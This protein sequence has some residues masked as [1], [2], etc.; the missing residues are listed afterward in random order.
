MADYSVTLD[1]SNETLGMA[2]I[3][4]MLAARIHGAIGVAAQNVYALW[5]DRVMKAPGIWH[6]ERVAYVQ[7]LK[8]NYTGD[9]SA[10]V[11]TDY[12]VADEIET[13]RP[14]RDL[15]RML[16]TSNKTRQGKNGKYLIIPFRHNVPS[17]DGH[18]SNARQ[19]PPEIYAMARKLPVSMTT[20]KTTRVSATG[21]TV[22]QSTY[23]WGG[24]LPAGL[25]PK[26]NPSHAS[27]PYAGM[28]KMREKGSSKA[29]GY[30]TFR[31]MTERS[32]GWIIPAKP[33]QFIARDVAKEAQPDVEAIIAGSMEG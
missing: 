8:W 9:L 1:F 25:A 28:V 21:A 17:G 22:P 33:G 11:W 10:R 30:L 24:R 32:P 27:D 16:Q 15:K 2:Q 14:S 3:N 23:K 20:G 29:S 13:G 12:K 5:A 19:M 18:S 26:L 31:V 4:K 6:P 7:S